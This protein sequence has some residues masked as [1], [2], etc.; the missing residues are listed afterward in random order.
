MRNLEQE[1]KLKLDEREYGILANLTD[2]EPQLQINYYFTSVHLPKNV[3][4][5]IRQKGDTFLLGYKERLQQSSGV[6]VCDERECEISP[7]YADSLIRRGILQHEINEMLKTDFYEMLTCEGKMETYRTAFDYM[8]W[9]FE[10]D[11]NLYLDIVDYELECE[12]EN[13]QDLYNLKNYLVYKFGIV[14]KDS[15][16]KSMRFFEA[17]NAKV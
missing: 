7:S 4:V 10:L 9:H 2:K 12:S 8:N 3:M 5:R 16:A 6:M 13:M 15:K 1:L 14:L 17:K 11:K